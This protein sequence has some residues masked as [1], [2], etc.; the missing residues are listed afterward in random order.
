[1]YLNCFYL[2]VKFIFINKFVFLYLIAFGEV[3]FTKQQQLTSH[4]IESLVHKITILLS[5]LNDCECVFTF[6]FSSRKCSVTL[7]ILKF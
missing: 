7:I 3:A 6:L 4:R 2:L 5:I 1:M